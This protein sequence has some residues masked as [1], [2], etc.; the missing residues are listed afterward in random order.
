MDEIPTDFD[1]MYEVMGEALTIYY[2]RD[3][4]HQGLWKSNTLEEGNHHITSKYKR[5]VQD[6]ATHI[7]DGLDLI[8]YV[9]FQI[10][11]VREGRV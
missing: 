10:V 2:Q 6:P 4:V 7:D 5:F 1:K 3:Q 8:N 11:N 9:A